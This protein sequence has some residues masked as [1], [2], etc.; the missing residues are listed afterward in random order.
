MARRSHTLTKRGFRRDVRFFLTALV[1]FL[2]TL[3]LVLVVMLESLATRVELAQH[4][5]RQAVADAIVTRLERADP[6]TLSTQLEEIRSQYGIGSIRL[7]RLEVGSADGETVSVVRV[8]TTGTLEVVFEASEVEAARRGG[9]LTIAISAAA[10]GLGLVLLF[11]YLPRIVDPVERMLDEAEALGGRAEGVDETRYLVETFRNTIETMKQQKEE[12][13]RLHQQERVRASDL[14][15]LTATLT[16]S[17]GSGFIAL[18][19]AGTIVDVNAAAR[20]ILR[21]EGHAN[22]LTIDSLLPGTEF[23]AV[24]TSA[25]AASESLSRVEITHGEK[26]IGLA[27]VPLVNDEGL[28]LGMMLLF[29]DVTEVRRLEERLRG[30]QALADLGEM[31]AGIAHEF[32]NAL[33]TILGNLRLARRG[34]AGPETVARI[35]AAEEEATSLSATVDALLRFARPMQLERNHVDLEALVVEILE[36]FGQRHEHITFTSQARGAT[37]IA[38]DAA[39]L[40][41]LFENLI[42]N[43]AEA[44]GDVPGSV[45]LSVEGAEEV[46][47]TVRDTGIGIEA[48]EIPRL[49]LPFQS[50][51]P[52]GVGL[53]LPLASKIA[54]LHGGSLSLASEPG[55][56]TS[57]VVTLPRGEW[58]DTG[59]KRN[60]TASPRL[61]PL[62]TE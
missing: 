8:L 40:R 58:V 54:I 61:S 43:A 34:G 6:A 62:R 44:V 27:T 38:G 26:L 39:A 31:S 3:V 1:G 12:L 49:L 11:L 57:V 51:R 14:E 45:S 28:S 60:T 5:R 7:G 20:D 52:G 30:Q 25:A 56:G 46:T 53:G 17:L 18:D 36:R 59:T 10:A 4:Q 55:A 50:N 2:V 16:R 42:R 29:T 41:A 9:R 23:A 21:I 35:A 19:P 48:A 47:V 37:T 22:G 24:A 13:H 33:A 32:R 15:L